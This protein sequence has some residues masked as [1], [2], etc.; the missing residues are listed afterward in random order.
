MVMIG[1][2]QC[3]TRVDAADSGD[4]PSDA[5]LVWSLT[6]DPGGVYQ[7][8][9]VDLARDR[10]RLALC[11][12]RQPRTMGIVLTVILRHT[13]RMTEANVPSSF[14]TKS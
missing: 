7:R 5:K 12:G 8:P 14:R 1:P 10:R 9:P 6:N 2:P 11:T 4:E 3:Y 13:I